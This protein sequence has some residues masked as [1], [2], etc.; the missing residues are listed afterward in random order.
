MGTHFVI[1]CGSRSIKLHSADAAAASL[2]AARSWDPI[3][4]AGHSERV[5]ALLAEL[6]GDLPAAAAVHVVGTAAARRSAAVALAIADACQA[7][8]WSYETLT[9]EQEA[10][11]ILE[12]FGGRRD[13]DIVNAGGGSIQIVD[14]DGGASLLPFGISD[15]NREFGLSLAP[16]LRRA[17]AA[18]DYVAAR[19]PNLG[20]PFL[21][22]GG[23]LSYLRA[24]GARTTDEGRCEE[25]EFDRVAARVDRMEVGELERLSPF[26]AGWC[27]GAVASNA[28]VRACF[29]RAG[30]GFYFASDV[31]IADGVMARLAR[32]GGNAADARL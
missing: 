20:R 16:Q 7:F 17:E 28:I 10:A 2:C 5:A 30:V 23:E 12:A 9:Q 6:T 26:D 4:D 8:G 3:N 15:L 25:A 22:S 19:L 1:D 14:A 18:T 29:R 21:Y 11:L 24:L 32:R 31:N 27:S 13:C